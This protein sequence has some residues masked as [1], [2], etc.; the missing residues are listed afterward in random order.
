MQRDRCVE[1]IARDSIPTVE[2]SCDTNETYCE[3]SQVKNGYIC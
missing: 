1:D 3:N 2:Q